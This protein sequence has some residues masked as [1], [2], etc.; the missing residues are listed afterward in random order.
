MATPKPIGH[1]IKE[2]VA[3]EARQVREAPGKRIREKTPD[4]PGANFRD[5]RTVGMIGGGILTI[6]EDTL[7]LPFGASSDI[8][9]T[10]P[11]KGGVVYTI[12]VNAPTQNV[13]E[14]RAF[15]DS[16]TGFSSYVTDAYDVSD[17]EVLNER[18][19]RDTY[20]VEIKVVS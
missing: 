14:A 15:L 19:L 18:L 8:V 10:R 11:V 12:N 4:P 13:A 20:Q 5:G 1:R 7:G 2:L 9:E 3:S 6:L 17:V 16:S